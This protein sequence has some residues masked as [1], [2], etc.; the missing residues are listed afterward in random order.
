MRLPTQREITIALLDDLA[1]FAETRSPVAPRGAT[2]KQRE[3]YQIKVKTIAGRFAGQ[4]R[5]RA[6]RLAEAEEHA[7]R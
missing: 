4:L 3:A 5:E 2:K 7:Q 6:R 1:S